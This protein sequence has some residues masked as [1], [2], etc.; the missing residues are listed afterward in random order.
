MN[1]PPG[2]I[3]FAAPDFQAPYSALSVRI[4]RVSSEDE[5]FAVLAVALKIPDYFGY[6]WNALDE[7]L[8]DLWWINDNDIFFL[9]DDCLEHVSRE[10][11]LIYLGIL[12]N[13][14]RNWRSTG[15]KNLEVVFPLDCQAEI[16]EILKDL[17][18]S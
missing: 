18:S 13:C 4:S 12:M 7:C 1:I 6:N 16:S 14:I 9:H 3:K 11:K 17:Q 8:H 2:A 15:Q 10:S 5:L